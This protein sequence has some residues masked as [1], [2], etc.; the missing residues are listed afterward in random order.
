MI[1]CAALASARLAFWM[2]FRFSQASLSRNP[3]STNV[4]ISSISSLCSERIPTKTFSA[5]R[6]ASAV[7]SAWSAALSHARR[8][9]AARTSRSSA[10]AKKRLA[11]RG[12]DWRLLVSSRGRAWHRRFFQ[13]TPG[14]PGGEARPLPARGTVPA[15]RQ[16]P[17]A[18]P[19]SPGGPGPPFR[20]G[21]RTPRVR[22]F[23]R[24]VPGFR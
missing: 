24:L 1:S 9:A 10:F 14:R 3:G 11:A 5:E 12:I 19:G 4:R 6:E 8:I 7:D 2:F 22:H 18:G 13:D 17:R 16:E 21:C 23:R 15:A 20:R